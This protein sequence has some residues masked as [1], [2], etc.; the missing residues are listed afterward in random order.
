[1]KNKAKW[2]SASPD[3]LLASFGSERT[4]GLDKKSVA[5]KRRRFGRNE[6]WEFDGALDALKRSSGTSL[7]GPALMLAA[8]IAAYAFGRC[9][10]LWLVIISLVL[11]L[12]LRGA[13]KI[14][15]TET[16]GKAKRAKIPSVTTV[17]DGVEVSVKADALVPGDIIVLRAGDTVPADCKLLEAEAL[18]VNEHGAGGEDKA[19][20]KN[21]GIALAAA[22]EALDDCIYAFSAVISGECRA[23]VVA[24][25]ERTLAVKNRGKAKL[26][27]EGDTERIRRLSSL[28]VKISTAAYI[29][30]FVSVIL[31]VLIPLCKLDFTGVFIIFL[32]FAVTS[33]GDL[34]PS[35]G[36]LLYVLE[37]R[38]ASRDGIRFRGADSY[39]KLTSCDTVVIADPSYLS[40]GKAELTG[41]FTA[42]GECDTE[43]GEDVLALLS[44]SVRGSSDVKR[45]SAVAHA[46]EDKFPDAE[47]RDAFLAQSAR[48]YYSVE[49]TF[50][51]SPGGGLTYTLY[52]EDNAFRFAAVGAIDDIIGRCT[53][54]RI[55]GRDEKLT[56]ANLAPLLAAASKTSERSSM[57]ICVAVRES[58]YN[59]L[60]R[61]SVLSVN[62]T[63]VGFVAVNVP[64][65]EGFADY[66]AKLEASGV[67]AVVLTDLSGESVSFERC[68]GIIGSKEDIITAE[69][70]ASAASAYIAEDKTVSAVYSPSPEFTDGFVT[71]LA[72]A[73]KKPLVIS[74]LDFAAREGCAFVSYG[75]D[76]PASDA[77]APKH[78]RGTCGVL[79]SVCRCTATE[80]TLGLLVRALLVSQ[81]VRLLLCLTA[82]FGTT[83]VYP[84]IVCFWGAVLDLVG[85]IIAV[86]RMNGAGK[87]KKR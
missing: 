69:S 73:G 2:A 52:F 16:D 6:L 35:V 12:C 31:G 87:R 19:I 33:C 39:E 58:P 20:Q 32:A 71:A 76:S 50:V 42:S 65:V 14:I 80:R 29:A 53:H 47:K 75:T 4:R 64:P 48:K 49:K 8:A 22:D 86:T 67:G 38:A 9:P 81:T 74:A 77:A 51:S 10:D 62:L 70:S 23:L 11:G 60:K 44:A 18:C 21:C 78:G 30:A 7:L 3:A 34:L 41:I 61:L 37:E 36:R 84:S 15:Y 45:S 27:G 54:I 83:F 40:S 25:G 72:K 17:R 5:E 82:V 56:S 24:T 79:D 59:S 57:L 28:G 68:A 1:M 46:V 26:A 13:I 66:T 63:L 85:I 43:E 55:N